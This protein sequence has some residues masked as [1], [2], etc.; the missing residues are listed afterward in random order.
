MYRL[1][2]R[3]AFLTDLRLDAESGELTESRFGLRTRLGSTWELLYALTFR[4]AAR[5]E[6]DVEFSVRVR[7]AQP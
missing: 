1:N 4:E 2:E 7:L 3:Y 6:S 5:R